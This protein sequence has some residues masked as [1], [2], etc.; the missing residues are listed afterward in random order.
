MHE[1]RE[2]SRSAPDSVY[3][4]SV[5]PTVCTTMLIP[6][7]ERECVF[8][9]CRYGDLDEI[10]QFVREHGNDSLTDLR[11]ENGN[12]VLHMCCANGHPG[13]QR[14]IPPLARSRLPY[15]EGRL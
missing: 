14:A 6:D 4:I 12:C 9:S 10:Q 1:A 11:D 2:P 5:I 3:C 15:F 7:D 13:K 8:L